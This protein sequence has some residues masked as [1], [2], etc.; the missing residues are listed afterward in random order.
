[1]SSIVLALQFNSILKHAQGRMMQ[2]HCS[3]DSENLLT[4]IAEV[5]FDAKEK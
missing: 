1:M 3:T 4:S 2:N 5:V